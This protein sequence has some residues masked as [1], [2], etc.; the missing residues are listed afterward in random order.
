[1]REANKEEPAEVVSSRS[2]SQFQT[3]F[4]GQKGKIIVEQKWSFWGH[5][6]HLNK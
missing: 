5:Q 4:G 6:L 1:M 3:L 2:Q